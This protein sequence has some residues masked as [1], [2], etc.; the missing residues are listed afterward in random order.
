MGRGYCYWHN[1]NNFLMKM[2]IQDF[3]DWTKSNGWVNEKPWLIIGKGPS[4][5]LINSYDTTDYNKVSLNHVA[6]DQSVSIAHIIDFDV[7]VDCAEKI[8]ENA[9]VLVMP[10]RPHIDNWVSI[11][12][13]DVLVNENEQLCRLRDEGR[14]KYYNLG[15]CLV[16]RGHS[17]IIPTNYFSSEA[18]V[19]LLFEIGVRKIRTIGVDG[20]VTY[21][22]AFEDLNKKTLLANGH[23]SFDLQFRSIAKKIMMENLDYAPLN[24][25]SPVKIYV[26]SMPEQMLAV[27]VLEYS[28]KKHASLPVEVFPLFKGNIDIPIP[29]DPKNRPRTPFSFQRFLIPQLN[30]H[31]GKA[32]YVDSDMQVFTDIKDLWGRDMQ[33]AHLYSAFE[34]SGI[35][36]K[37]QFSVMLM[38][39][40]SLKWD[41]N[42]I[43]QRLDSNELDYEKLMYEMRV[44]DK[45]EPVIEFEWNSLEF[46]EFGKTKLL[47]YTD[48]NRQPWLFTTNPLTK[49]WVKELHEAVIN[50][51]ITW[52]NVRKQIMQGNVRPSL[53]FQLKRKKFDIGGLTGKIVRQL[54]RFYIPPY[55]RSSKNHFKMILNKWIAFFLTVII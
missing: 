11:K 23:P 33:G 35:G 38:D 24:V 36:R 20:G 4:Y 7:A 6:R 54:D 26:G 46:F 32:I 12:T 51:F 22:E 25:P 1:G 50:N 53:W 39:C 15:S 47:H 29:K 5:A 8:Y 9:D 16:P 49:I 43:V 10:W 52:G 30:G 31:R 37:P 13:L 45:V 42:E 48:M 2:E 28:I 27:K 18:V 17:A 55:A 34:S 19:N 3:F 14:I 21:S 41:I 40:E 44:A